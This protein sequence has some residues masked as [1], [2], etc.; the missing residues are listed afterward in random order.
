MLL[1]LLCSAGLFL[2]C[3][4]WGF[5]LFWVGLFFKTGFLCVAG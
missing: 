5:C 2:F 4:V 1:L 3:F